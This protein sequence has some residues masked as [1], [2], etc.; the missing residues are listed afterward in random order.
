[1]K[2]RHLHILAVLIALF[3]PF[4]VWA[5]Y[6][7]GD[8]FTVNGITYK[9]TCVSPYE[10]QV[11]D[12]NSCVRTD[13]TGVITIPKYLWDDEGN[14]YT[15]TQIGK[16]AFRD[17]MRI[18]SVEIPNTVTTIESYAFYCCYSLNNIVIPN[19][20]TAIKEYAFC[21]CNSLTTI[22]IPSS[23]TEI[24]RNPFY[25]TNLN[26]ITVDSKNSVFDSRYD[27]NAIIRKANNELATG[28]KNT[29]IPNGI[30]TIGAYAFRDCKG[31]TE[32][33]IPNSVDSICGDAFSKSGLTKVSIPSS[34]SYIYENPFKDTPWY[35]GLDD[36]LIY[37]DNVFLG[38]KGTKPEGNWEIEPGTR[39]IATYALSGCSSVTIPNSVTSI[40]DNSTNIIAN[41]PVT[42]FSALCTN[43]RVP[44]IF[45]KLQGSIRLID[46]NKNEIKEYVVPDGVTS[47][48]DY[49]F[50]HCTGLTRVSI[51]SSV[52]SIGSNAF[53]YCENLND[54]NISEGVKKI[55]SY[56]FYYC[57]GLS[58][59]TIPL[60][61]TTMGD[62]IFFL[63]K[64]LVSATIGSNPGKKAFDTC[65]KLESVT[66][67]EGLTNIGDRLFY[68]CKSLKNI[69]LSSTITSIGEY[70]FY[71][72]DGLTSISI[73]SGITDWGINAFANC[74]GLTIVTCASNPGEATFAR[75]TNLTNVTLTEGVTDIGHAAFQNCRGLE[76]IS[77]P[78]SVTNI[79]K[80]AFFGCGLQYVSLPNSLKTIEEDLFYTCPNLKEISIPSSVTRIGSCAFY[81]CSSL[82]SITLA[83]SG[84]LTIG[85]MV[86]D[87]CDALTSVYV[88]DLETWLRME[89]GS[90]FYPYLYLDNVKATGI[91]DIVI[92]D[93][94]TC[95]VNSAFYEWANLKSVTIPS[96]LDSISTYSF[97][98]CSSLEAVH[99]KDLAAW[100]KIKLASSKYCNPLFTAKHLYM[101]G[102][103][104]KDLVIPDGVTAIS[105]YAF[106]GC[107]NLTSV[108][109]PSSL[110]KI[111]IG[112]FEGCTGLTAVH[113]KDIAAWCKMDIEVGYSNPDITN[114]L[115]IAQHL[116]IDGKEVTDLVIPEGA[117]SI[118]KS[119]FYGWNNLKAIT[120]PSSMAKVDYSFDSNKG[121]AAVNIK[122]LSA[123]CGIEFSGMW[124][125]PIKVAK[126]IYMNSQEVTDLVIPNG[127]PK[128]GRYAFNNCEG[129]TSLTISSG[130]S[131]IEPYAFFGCTGLESITSLIEEPF[132]ISEY[133]FMYRDQDD[134]LTFNPK[135][136]LYVPSGTKAKYEAV[137]C[138]NWFDN[139]IETTYI[140]PLDVEVN[141]D[142]S[143]LDGQDLS[144]NVVND[145]YYNTGD[146]SYD[147]TDGSIVISQTTNMGEITNPVPGSEDVKNN[148]TGII[149]RVAAGKGTLKVN[150]KTSGN[151]QLVVQIGNGTPMIATKTEKD[152]VVV[153]YDVAEDTYIYIYA[154][155]GSSAANSMRAASADEVR[156]Y[157][158]TVTPEATGI[159]SIAR[160]MTTNNRYYTLDGRKVDGIPSKKGLYI[161]NGKNVVVK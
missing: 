97:K 129:L 103:E 39:V 76:S 112:A 33:S 134:V 56:A 75:C 48:G 57:I 66:F 89:G 52:D 107:E 133:V 118:N 85:S 158:I 136:P 81:G 28:C 67:M 80:S 113:V 51:P 60:G 50:Y 111:H 108:T 71:G 152:E 156:I 106:G 37:Q 104:V 30:K 17:C 137:S 128:I 21:N 46:E 12:D 49:A 131:D 117:T 8:S 109:I 146:D 10:V 32:I 100:C 44:Y 35:E 145:V 40:G 115:T 23:V 159:N 73:A 110:A 83:P 140:E 114:P 148:F 122:D 161:V 138:W 82:S 135:I 6:D 74:T 101:N 62:N 29:K 27:C 2:Q 4:S 36:G 68:G 78:K 64:N 26:S 86:I 53:A 105:K 143:N 98:G 65:D 90:Q 125:N 102:Q 1:M 54:I 147:A 38:C 132:T 99:I 87:D 14:P 150:V 72:C 7:I 155:I 31:L 16:K 61:V 45:S 88:K 13:T 22:D 69:T 20:V 19:S 121:I 130:V 116:F 91:T 70:A 94:T 24:V 58:D 153:N 18:S 79:G 160:E 139:I 63:C 119:V 5:A 47:I 42:D 149:L 3:I 93:G 55:G 59:I 9:V 124:S 142:T 15:V 151:A 127:T 120:F 25:G 84:T 92:P 95:L 96:S 141:I 11:G 126:H 41:I 77:L 144:D 154:I 34:V 43:G 157:G 123:W